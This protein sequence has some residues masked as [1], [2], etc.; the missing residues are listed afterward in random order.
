MKPLILDRD[1]CTLAGACYHTAPTWQSDVAHICRWDFLGFS[2]IGARGTASLGDAETDI[3]S[4]S[5]TFKDSAQTVALD[6]LAA[7]PRD[8][9]GIGHS[10]GGAQMQWICKWA[11]Q[12]GKAPFALVTFGSPRTGDLGPEMVKL[13]GTDYINKRDPVPG[14]P[15][16]WSHPRAT[17]AIGA[18]A[19]TDYLAPI[20]DHYIAGYALSMATITT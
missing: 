19:L 9:I 14:L 7:L 8:W 18:D 13:A 17:M 4:M 10:L 12:A 20:H 3:A 6:I 15:L 2:V 16:F 5:G 11:I 1:L